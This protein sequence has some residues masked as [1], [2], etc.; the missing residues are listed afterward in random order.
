MSLNFNIVQ[1]RI[2]RPLYW[3]RNEESNFSNR[4][5][6]VTFDRFVN[7]MNDYYLINYSGVLSRNSWMVFSWILM[8]IVENGFVYDSYDTI[9]STFCKQ[10]NKMSKPTFFKCIDELEKNDL[11]SSI[12]T[13]KGDTINGSKIYGVV[14]KTFYAYQLCD[15]IENKPDMSTME[16]ISVLNQRKQKTLFDIEGSEPKTE[17][18]K[19]KSKLSDD[20]KYALLMTAMFK[21]IESEINE[22]FEFISSYNKSKR[23]AVSRKLKII[24]GLKQY[25]GYGFE[26]SD[27]VHA[28]R[29]TM[30]NTVRGHNPYRERYMFKI[31]ENMCEPDEEVDNEVARELSKK[32]EEKLSAERDKS[33]LKYS[34]PSTPSTTKAQFNAERRRLMSVDH[35]YRNVIYDYEH[36]SNPND[37][38]EYLYRL[39][40]AIKKKFD[41]HNSYDEKYWRQRHD[42]LADEGYFEHEEFDNK[43]NRVWSYEDSKGRY[44]SQ[45][46][47][48]AILK[49]HGMKL[50]LSKY[51]RIVQFD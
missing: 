38:D 4:Y 30:K 14:D 44:I 1:S 2:K 34:K 25:L 24:R 49:K 13:K 23:I 33:K 32:A 40:T 27:F 18:K 26:L 29:V 12:K 11:I 17:K 5:E 22:F 36:N 47:V 9:V 7:V 21:P 10:G 19:K 41:I 43:W 48:E 6:K 51:E 45:Q 15:I 16:A 37:Y 31:L 35:Y 20:K 3:P 46:E 42:C 39:A 50:V 28:F 8:L